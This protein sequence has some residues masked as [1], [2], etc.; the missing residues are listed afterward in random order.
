MHDEENDIPQLS[1]DTLQLLREFH[2]E[3]DAHAKLFEDLKA[4]AEDNFETG[5][6]KLTMDIFS[7]DW[8]ASQF[9]YTD[10]TARA[11]ARQLLEDVDSDSAVAVISAPS[12]YVQLR[13]ILAEDRT[14][15]SKPK[16]CLLE[17]DT[18]FEVFGS[19]FVTYDFEKP[20]QL[21]LGLKGKFDRIIC[22]PPFLSEDCQTKTA[23]TVRHLAR[24]WAS[25]SSEQGVLRLISC[26]GERMGP[27]I[28]KLYGKI[29][30]RPTSFEPEH[31]RGLS[32]EFVCYSNFECDDWKWR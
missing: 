10:S 27:T 23:L 28:S 30:M 32:N 13:N 24:H 26:T 18:R 29:G 9:W 20:L 21:P 1:G 7:E 16:I 2:S 15:S 31:S 3:R 22:D 8:N 6:A 12:V 17:Y 19:D 5:N 4:Q 25:P 11:L 14:L